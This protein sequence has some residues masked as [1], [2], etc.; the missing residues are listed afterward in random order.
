MIEDATSDGQE[1]FRIGKSFP[2]IEM[3]VDGLMVDLTGS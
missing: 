3:M 1:S 2:E